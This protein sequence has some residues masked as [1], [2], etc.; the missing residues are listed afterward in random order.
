MGAARWPLRPLRKLRLRQMNPTGEPFTDALTLLDMS[1][2]ERADFYCAMQDWSPAYR[3]KTL[4]AYDEMV[5]AEKDR[6]LRGA[7]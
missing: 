5:A 7:L 1:R 2:E 4:A 6:R 3:E